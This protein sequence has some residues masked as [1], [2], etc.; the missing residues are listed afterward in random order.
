MCTIVVGWRETGTAAWVIRTRGA[1]DI[2]KLLLIG[3]RRTVATAGGVVYPRTLMPG[4]CC[5]RSTAVAHSGIAAHVATG[6]N[7]AASCEHRD[8]WG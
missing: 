8:A 6:G 5:R 2:P 3:V 1:P 7:G 4:A